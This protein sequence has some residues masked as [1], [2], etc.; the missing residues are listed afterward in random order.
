[1][2]TLLV[3]LIVWVVLSIPV[4]LLLARMFRSTGGDARGRGGAHPR[5]D[6]RARGPEEPE[7]SRFYPEIDRRGGEFSAEFGAEEGD[8]H[9]VFPPR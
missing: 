9:R 4:A 6:G 7:L 8:T 1:M 3:V 5:R 2:T